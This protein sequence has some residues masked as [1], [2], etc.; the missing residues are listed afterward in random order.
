[1]VHAYNAAQSGGAGA[2]SASGV[3]VDA[4]TVRIF[5]AVLE[6]AELTGG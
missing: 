3:L 6:R 1:M 4:A 5:Q 2:G